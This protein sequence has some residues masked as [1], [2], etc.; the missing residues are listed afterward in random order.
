LGMSYDTPHCIQRVSSKLLFPV[1]I[2]VKFKFD[3]VLN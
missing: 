3:A 2:I 1:V